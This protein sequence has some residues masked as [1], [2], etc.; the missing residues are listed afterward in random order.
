MHYVG[1]CAVWDVGLLLICASRLLAS[2]LCSH[3]HTHAHKPKW[4][5]YVQCTHFSLHTACCGR[6][7]QKGLRREGRKEEAHKN[8]RKA[9]NWASDNTTVPLVIGA[10][11]ERPGKG[12]CEVK[13]IVNL[14]EGIKH[15]RAALN[16]VYTPLFSSSTLLFAKH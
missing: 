9:G 7:Y 11:A 1:K 15:S 3:Q 6:N 16:T 4:P 12:F 5:L 13:K 2:P 14:L 10:L 8:N